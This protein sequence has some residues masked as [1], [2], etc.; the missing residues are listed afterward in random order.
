ME[1]SDSAGT[2]STGE[3]LTTESGVTVTSASTGEDAESQSVA[4]TRNDSLEET[5]GQDTKGQLS[6][7]STHS[8]PSSETRSLDSSPPPEDVEPDVPDPFLVDDPEDPLSDEELGASVLQVPADEIS[9]AR[10]S[11][12]PASPVTPVTPLTPNVNKAVPPPPETDEDEDEGPDLYLPGL[13]IPTMF[14]PIPNVRRFT[15]SYHLLWWLSPR[16]YL[17]Y[18]TTRPIR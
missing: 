12:Q 16:P 3:A 17:M 5:T 9:L 8:T 2:S 7:E 10:S 13:V 11:S 6:S 4:I 18:N 1:R 15:L 14:L